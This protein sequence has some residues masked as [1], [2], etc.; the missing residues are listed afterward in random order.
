[1]MSNSLKV[2][3]VDHGT[4]AMV[5]SGHGTMVMVPSGHLCGGKRC[6]DQYAIWSRESICH[7]LL[8]WGV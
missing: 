4:M 5:P 3:L 6:L 8:L 7:A 1:M 2:S